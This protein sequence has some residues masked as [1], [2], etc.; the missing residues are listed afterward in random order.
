MMSLPLFCPTLKLSGFSG[1]VQ[2]TAQGLIGKTGFPF[3]GGQLNHASVRML[4]HSLQHVRQVGHR[5]LCHASGAGDQ[6]ALYRGQALRTQF[7]P[8][9]KPIFLIMQRLAQ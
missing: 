4:A 6:Q 3:P 1:A 2:Q 7:R 8:A 9:K 5:G